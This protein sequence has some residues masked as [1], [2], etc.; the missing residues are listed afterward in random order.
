MLALNASFLATM[1]ARVGPGKWVLRKL[2]LT[3]I[4]K[5]A[6]HPHDCHHPWSQASLG[7][8]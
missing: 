8:S 5:P 4:K 6:C 3:L 2:W 7:V 1:N